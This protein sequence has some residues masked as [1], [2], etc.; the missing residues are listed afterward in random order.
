MSSIAPVRCSGGSCGPSP[1]AFQYSE[2]RSDSRRSRWRRAS[3]CLAEPSRVLLGGDEQRVLCRD[4]LPLPQR[5]SAETLHLGAEAGVLVKRGGDLLRILLPP[6]HRHH[7]P[8]LVGVADHL[9]AVRAIL[10]AVKLGRGHGRSISIEHCRR[11]GLQNGRAVVVLAEADE[12]TA[13]WADAF[14]ERVAAVA[15]VAIASGRSTIADA[16]V[17][18]ALSGTLGKVAHDEAPD[19]SVAPSASVRPAPSSVPPSVTGHI[20]R[21]ARQ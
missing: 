7:D 20:T 10:R 3:P 18:L 8:R 15:G 11:L 5:L 12:R 13:L 2:D 6:G 21:P 19:E 9:R 17:A 16:A 14:E 4:A 1:S